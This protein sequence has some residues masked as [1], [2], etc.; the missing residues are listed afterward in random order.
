[1]PFILQ[2]H[3]RNATNLT[4]FVDGSAFNESFGLARDGHLLLIHL[5]N[6]EFEVVNPIGAKRGKHK[7]NAT[8]F[9]LGNLPSKYRS[10][11]QHIYLTNI[12]RHKAVKDE[13]YNAVFTPLVNELQQLYED[14]F[15]VT[16][17]DGRVEKFYAILCTVSG[18]NL[19]SHA[20]AGFRQV[21]NS[22]RICRMCMISYSELKDT[23]SEKDVILRTKKT[24]EYHVQAAMENHDNAAIY[25]VNEPSI[26][27]GLEYFDVTMGFPPDIMHDCMEGVI[28]KITAA[29]IEKLVHNK[30]VTLQQLNKK[31]SSFLLKGHDSINRPEPVKF[32]Q[33]NCNIIGSASQK[34]C[35]FR[36]LPFFAT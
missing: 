21:F 13:G 22:G 14:G 15:T 33:G 6:D 34:M 26:F 18:D 35:L 27:S 2:S 29:I 32:V 31:M 8:Y 1:M 20:L 4:S 5:Y 17:K 10:N 24:H 23:I 9:T 19:S 11:L 12:V 36:F 30:V 25:G 28:P 3:S 7:I 16:W